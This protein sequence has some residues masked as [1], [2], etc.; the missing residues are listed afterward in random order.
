MIK[1]YDKQNK[2]LVYIDT[3]ANGAFWDSIWNVDNFEELVKIKNN[4]FII[5]NTKRYLPTGSR[6]LEGG[7][8]RGDKVYALYSHGYDVYGVDYAK[9]TIKKINRCVP[10]I[11]VTY[12]DVRKL[13]FEDGFFDGYWSLG[14]IEHFY[15]GYDEIINEMYRVLKHGGVLFMTVPSMSCIRKFKAKVGRYPQYLENEEMVKNFY[16]FVLN[17]KQVIKKFENK[18]FKLLE[19]RKIEGVYGVSN[20]VNFLGRVFQYLYN[21]NTL[22][23]RKMTEII[24]NTFA[25]HLSFY[26]MKRI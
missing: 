2:C 9:E 14:V 20:E 19:I 16:Q 5:D 23:I 10:E 11:K 15:N 18:G 1:Y 13:D 17:P 7:C 22:A 12:G 25:N 24:A 26:I 4:P 6:I 3:G 8:G 21:S